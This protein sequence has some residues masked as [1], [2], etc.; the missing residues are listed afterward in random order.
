MARILFWV[1]FMICLAQPMVIPA[2]GVPG[3]PDPPAVSPRVPSTASS[4][5][6]HE[7]RGPLL[8]VI[9]NRLYALDRGRPVV[10]WRTDLGSNLGDPQYSARGT[11]LVSAGG[12]VYSVETM[13]G[14]VR[15]SRSLGM[16]QAL[17]SSFRWSPPREESDRVMVQAGE[18]IIA[19]DA[20][21]GR[22]CWMRP[23]RISMLEAIPGRGV[24]SRDG[25]V[26]GFDLASGKRVWMLDLPVYSSVPVMGEGTLVLVGGYSNIL[27]ALDARE[28]KIQWS[29]D[30]GCDIRMYVTGMR[31]KEVFV[32]ASTLLP[33]L[34]RGGAYPLD[35]R[36]DTSLAVVAA[37]SAAAGTVRWRAR[38]ADSNRHEIRE[39]LIDGDV[40]WV[41]LAATVPAASRGKSAAGYHGFSRRDGRRIH[42][43]PAH[44]GE[45]FLG[46]NQGIILLQRGGR[47]RA[48]AAATGREV[49]SRDG[50]CLAYK[51][52]E[53][54][55]VIQPAARPA[56]LESYHVVSGEMVYR[57]DIRIPAR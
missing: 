41:E 11:V 34:V 18:L 30:L 57:Y 9:K 6:L 40:L 25:P 52:D 56:V 37:L 51:P 44:P 50:R 2:W 17:R 45:V 38:I 22:P 42:Y 23:G 47:V 24:I 16:G 33:D 36:R 29:R 46:V 14:A 13:E 31:G 48:V 49:W 43:L 3:L 5:D 21:N 4:L 28:G 12:V 15:W 8:L 20:E 7:D 27:Y 1:L 54:L 19:L 32:G 26:E 39:M 35:N 10:M 53:A 55:V